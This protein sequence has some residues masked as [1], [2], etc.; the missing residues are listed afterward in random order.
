MRAQAK[1][2]AIAASV[3]IGQQAA[4]A[5]LIG[6]WHFNGDAVAQTGGTLTAGDGTLENIGST[7]PVVTDGQ[8]SNA[9]GALRFNGDNYYVEFSDAGGLNGLTTGSVAF[10]CAMERNTDG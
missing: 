1:V 7:D 10:F 2:L 4:Q 9:G 6:R 5:D 3:L 8:H